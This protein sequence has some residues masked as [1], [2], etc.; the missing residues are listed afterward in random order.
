MNITYLETMPEKV[1]SKVDLGHQCDE[2]GKGIV[3]NYKKF[4]IVANDQEEIGVLCAYT[5]F[6]EVYVDD[7]W[8]DPAFRKL[9][10]GRK[11][12]KTLE[13]RFLGEGYNNINLVTSHFTD[14]MEFYKRCGFELEFTRVNKINPK[15]TKYFFIKYFT[16]QDQT[17]GIL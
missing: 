6:G 4:Y 3:C 13:N 7:L 14:A 9:G 15:L 10:I 17:Q 12:L 2:A 5:A 8:V 11:L 1:Q 16:N